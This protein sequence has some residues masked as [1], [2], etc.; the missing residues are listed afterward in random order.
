MREP[1]RIGEKDLDGTPEGSNGLIKPPYTPENP[2]PTGINDLDGTDEGALIV[3]PD[4]G[5][6]KP[7]KKPE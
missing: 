6:V 7:M 1:G 5:E 4:T 3:D 2:T